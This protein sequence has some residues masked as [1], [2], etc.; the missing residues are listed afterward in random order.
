MQQ[1]EILRAESGINR[2][3]ARYADAVFRK[4][5]A[6]FA[7][8]LTADSEWRI[9]GRV[10]RGRAEC[11]DFVQERMAPMRWVLMTFRTP[12]LE[13]GPGHAISRS[14]VTEQSA[15]L[16]GGSGGTVATYH[17]RLVEQDG[18]WRRAWALFQLHYMG[19]ADLSGRFFPQPDY[20]PPGA[21]PPADV[22]S[23]APIR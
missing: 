16:D 12:L 3:H 23:T 7:D 5:F 2:L 6:S 4:D 14:Y 11:V 19:P 15:G 17:E 10:L 8:C 20:G 18:I 13:I 1:I 21:M 9:G 22:D